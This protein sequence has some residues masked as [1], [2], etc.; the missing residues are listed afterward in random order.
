[1]G[2]GNGCIVPE[3][4]L[5]HGRA[6]DLTSADDDAVAAGH[7]FPSLVD[8]LHAAIRSAGQEAGGAVHLPV[9]QFTRIE[10]R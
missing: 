1:M 4:E 6:D 8:Q 2:D 9:K 5:S 7:T 10:I 3:E